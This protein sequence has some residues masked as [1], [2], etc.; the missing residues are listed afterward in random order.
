MQTKSTLL[1]PGTTTFVNIRMEKVTTTE[2]ARKKSP[3]TRQ[4]IFPDEGQLTHFKTYTQSN[5][6]ID[7]VIKTYEQDCGCVGIY[8]GR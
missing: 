5:C 1:S 7:N 6:Y 2:A 4:C 8:R 3:E